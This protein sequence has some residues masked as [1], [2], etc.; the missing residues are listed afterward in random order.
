MW[1]GEVEDDCHDYTEWPSNVTESAPLN[2]GGRMRASHPR[3][4]PQAGRTSGSQ[5]CFAN[6]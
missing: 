6:D 2:E 3:A 4:S 1:V 5:N